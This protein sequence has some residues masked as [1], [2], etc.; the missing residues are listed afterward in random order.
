MNLQENISRVKKL[1]G[2]LGLH[3]EFTDHLRQMGRLF[4]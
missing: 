4:N 2:R 3:I 1:M